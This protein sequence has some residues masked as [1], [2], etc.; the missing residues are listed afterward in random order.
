MMNLPS[1]LHLKYL[2]ILQKNR[3]EER[4]LFVQRYSIFVRMTCPT[5]TE[6]RLPHLFYGALNIYTLTLTLFLRNKY[7]TNERHQVLRVLDI[8]DT[9]RQD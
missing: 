9:Y 7:V 6:F 5:Q 3:I 1:H 2:P 8:E 4:K